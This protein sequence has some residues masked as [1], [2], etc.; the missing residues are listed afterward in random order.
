MTID[1]DSEDVKQTRQT[2]DDT[3]LNPDFI[4]DVGGDPYVDFSTN[5]DMVEDL[6][7]TGSKP[8]GFHKAKF[9]P[10]PIFSNY[11]HA[12]RNLYLLTKSSPKDC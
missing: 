7:K 5:S 3:K 4:F 9:S 8:V 1:S 6:V 10:W 12:C 2:S 11:L